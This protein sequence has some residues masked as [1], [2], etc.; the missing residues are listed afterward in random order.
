MDFDG[1]AR[2]QFGGFDIGAFEFVPEPST[3]SVVIVGALLAG[4]NRRCM[5]R[6]G[7]QSADP[8]KI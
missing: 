5:R 6:F 3:M 1:T 8:Q 7:V 2:P 4:L